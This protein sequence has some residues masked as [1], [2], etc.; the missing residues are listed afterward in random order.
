[1][2]VNCSTG[3]AGEEYQVPKAS[4]SYRAKR[5]F[6]KCTLPH[7]ICLSVPLRQLGTIINMFLSALPDRKHLQ[8]KVMFYLLSKGAQVYHE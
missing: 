4:L 2:P 7:V 8:D 1:M 5:N 6:N 3:E